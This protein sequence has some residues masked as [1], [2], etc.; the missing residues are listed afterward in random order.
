MEEEEEEEEE[1]NAKTSSSPG[2]EKPGRRRRR[3]QQLLSD[4][5]SEIDI[6]GYCQLESMEEKVEANVEENTPLSSEKMARKD[7]NCS[8]NEEE[9]ERIIIK[10][11]KHIKRQNTTT[12]WLV[13]AMIILTLAWQ[14]SEISLILKIK[15]GF[16]NPLKSVSGMIGGFFK[17]RRRQVNNVPS[18]IKEIPEL[19]RLGLPGFDTSDDDNDDED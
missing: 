9:E 7:G 5:L 17:N 12:H 16:T 4:L 1:V 14:L 19:P 13:S 8:N 6:L 10:E 15:D 3:R 11:L 18:M 2:N